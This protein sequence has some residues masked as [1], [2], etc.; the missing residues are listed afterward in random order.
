MS[1]YQEMW[2]SID[3]LSTLINR[4][5]WGIAITLLITFVLT[6]IVIK[7]GNRKDALLRVSE[8]ER[9]DRISHANLLA[10]QANERAGTLEKEAADLT[11]KNLQLEAAIS[12]RR[13][14]QRQQSALA[15]LPYHDRSVE[16]KSYSAD[17]EGLVLATQIVAGLKKSKLE[18]IDNRL[19]MQPAGSL[20]FGVQ[21]EGTDQKLISELKRVLSLDGELTSTS[22]VSAHS[23]FSATVA[24]GGVSRSRPAAAII[25]V[26]AKPLN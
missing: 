25:I 2:N 20:M 12:P 19:T 17:T 14:T 1:W 16:I 26:G 3:R 7:A 5:N 22:S 8:L 24:F 15:N 10:A 23:G 13:L 21:V 6:V 4:A 9:E 11:A 18:I